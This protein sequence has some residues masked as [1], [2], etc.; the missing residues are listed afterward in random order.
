MSKLKQVV[1]KKAKPIG[2][3]PA[4]ALINP[5][6][7]RNIGQ[8][9]RSASCFGVKQVWYTGNRAQIGEGKRLPRE[10]RMKGYANVDLIHFDYFFEQFPDAIPVGVEVLENAEISTTFEHP[11]KAVYVFGPEDGHIPQTVRRHCHRFVTIPSAH[12]LNLSVAVSLILYDRRLKRQQA[13]LEPILP[14]ASVLEEPRRWTEFEQA[15][16]EG[17]YGKEKKTLREVLVG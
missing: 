5:K 16:D 14:P 3:T 1:S 12:C 9:I 7:P 13:G 4:V 2:V 17:D 15:A 10:E 11:E 8:V 6:Y